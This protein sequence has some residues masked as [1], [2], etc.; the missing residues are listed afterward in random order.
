MK[1]SV[2]PKFKKWMEAEQLGENLYVC[3][4]VL[5]STV[6][7]ISTPLRNSWNS[8]LENKE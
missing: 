7:F 3:G 5:K 8:F 1:T 4:W 2:E 6:D